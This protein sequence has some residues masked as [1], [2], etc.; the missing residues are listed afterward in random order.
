ML[1]WEPF[2]K[3]ICRLKNNLFQD[4]MGA[5][6]S[7]LRSEEAEDRR[8]IHVPLSCQLLNGLHVIRVIENYL[9]FLLNK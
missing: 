6:I 5:N 9:L 8:H 3:G 1:Q 7:V 4:G 2:F